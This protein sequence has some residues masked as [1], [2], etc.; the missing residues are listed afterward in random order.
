MKTHKLISLFALVLA[1]ALTACSA[2]A[3][4]LDL[5]GTSWALVE[6]SGQPVVAGSSPTLSFEEEQAG[7]SGSCNSFGGEYTLDNGKLT[8]GP[9]MSTMMYCKDT[10]EQE[11][12]YLAALQSA[13]AYQ[14]EDG[15]LLILDAEGVVVLTFEP[16]E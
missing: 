7:G 9:L 5:K 11:T 2:G 3:S 16:Q 12:A 6:I 4:T 13:A 14:M 10:M 15:R 8:F 1:L